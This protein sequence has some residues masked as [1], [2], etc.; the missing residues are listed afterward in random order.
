MSSEWVKRVN[1]VDSLFRKPP[2]YFSNAHYLQYFVAHL[3]IQGRNDME[4]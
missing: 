2:Q 4:E 3:S 1:A